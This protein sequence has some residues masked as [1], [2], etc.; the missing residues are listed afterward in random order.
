MKTEQELKNILGRNVYK[1]R[2]RMGWNQET[3]AEKV[4]VS[5]NTISDIE[6]GQKFA[7]AKTLV[8]LAEALQTEVY[9][10][11]KPD[12]IMPDKSADVLTKYSEE[13]KEAVE[14]IGNLYIEKMN[15]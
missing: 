4:C 10:L 7:R 11:L 2:D 9:E 13:V 1:L 8:G 3:L 14:K 15:Q 6:T 5:K 12:N